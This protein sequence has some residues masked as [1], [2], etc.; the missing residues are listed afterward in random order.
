[1]EKWNSSGLHRL[2]MGMCHRPQ[3]HH[4]AETKRAPASLDRRAIRVLGGELRAHYASLSRSMPL[5]L[6]ELLQQLRNTPADNE[7][8]ALRPSNPSQR[9]LWRPKDVSTQ[10]PWSFS[11]LHLRTPG[12]ACRS[13]EFRTSHPS[14]SP[15]DS[16]ASRRKENVTRSAWVPRRS[17]ALLLKAPKA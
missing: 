12:Q 3:G 8:P 7:G 2:D 16:L 15:D 10:P 9:F 4:M 14:N 6:M 11:T 1:M 17:L 5:A 13:S